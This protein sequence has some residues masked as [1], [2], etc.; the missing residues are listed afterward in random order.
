MNITA[1]GK[2]K[3]VALYTVDLKDDNT[4]EGKCQVVN[5]E[6]A[7]FNF[8]KDY[9]EANSQDEFIENL[10]NENAGLHIHEFNIED[11]DSLEKPV[12]EIYDFDITNKISS[13]GDEIYINPLLTN[14]ISDNPFKLDSRQFPVDYGYPI[15]STYIYNYTIPDNYEIEEVPKPINMGLSSKGAYFLYNVSK[16]GNRIVISCRLTISKD[17]FLP[18]EYFELKEFYNQIIKKETEPIVLKK[19]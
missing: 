6:Y 9:Q 7:A 12:K 2:D 18:G 17:T 14:Q 4:L 8:R 15:E 19:T 3:S 11:L 16:S 10:E 1:P 5:S 13:V